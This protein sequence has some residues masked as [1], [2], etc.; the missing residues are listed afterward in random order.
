MPE[1]VSTFDSGKEPL[2]DLLGDIGKGKIQLPDFQRGWVWDDHHIVSL[3]ASVAQAYPIGAV[4]SLET[5]NEDVRFKTRTFTG[6]WLSTSVEPEKLIL[7]GQQRLTSLYQALFSKEAVVTKDTKGNEFKRFYFIDIAKALG[8]DD[9]EEAII[10]VPEKKKVLNFR[11]EVQADYTTVALQ[12]Q[13]GVFPLN[14]VFDATLKGQWQVAFL[15]AKG[16]ERM[17]EQLTIWTDF[18]TR[19]LSSIAQYHLPVIGL[20]K[21]T[22]KAAI[23]QVFEKVNTG[24]VSL[25]VFELLTATFAVDNFNLREEWALR[26]RAFSEFAILQKLPSDN[27]LQVVSLLST[28]QRREMAQAGGRQE[29][30][31]PPVSCKRKDILKLRLDEYRAWSDQVQ[32]GFV[33]AARFLHSQFIFDQQDIPYNTQ[34][35]P[36]AGILVRLGD[37]F[38]NDGVREKVKRWFWCGLLGEQYGSATETRF[39][40]DLPEVLSWVDGGTEPDTVRD[41]SFS[42]HRLLSLRSRLSA[43]YKGVYA[44]LMKHQAL[45]FG[46]GEPINQISYFDDA[47][48]IHHVFPKKWCD[49]NGISAGVRDCIV[50]KTPLSYKTNRKIGGAAP[51]EYLAKLRRETG[52]DEARQGVI[53]ATHLLT[54]EALFLD[55]FARHFDDRT[56]MILNSIAAAMGKT[57]EMPEGQ[58]LLAEPA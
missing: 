52:N 20:K 40:K 29:D 49:E 27:F 35:V 28:L 15:Q 7:D 51:S 48:D 9:L 58:S 12:C 18:D 2:A 55:D 56:R 32:E 37:R 16:N 30:G 34:L 24:G 54:A 45:D 14:L 11:G 39:A 43:A 46:S 26:E 38:Q 13:Q 6:V 19:I 3:L 47:I 44:L 53:M 23:C 36:L 42:P 21:S 1:H 57:V 31:L 33:Q 50:N 17:P 22:S 10:S 5:G 8:S 4:M 41:A 25:T